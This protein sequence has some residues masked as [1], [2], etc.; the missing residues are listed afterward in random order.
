MHMLSL[1]ARIH[2]YVYKHTPACPNT[3]THT[4]QLEMDFNEKHTVQSSKSQRGEWPQP[5]INL[6]KKHVV[7]QAGF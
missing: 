3:G 6:L 7:W 1:W 5:A 2:I 4:L